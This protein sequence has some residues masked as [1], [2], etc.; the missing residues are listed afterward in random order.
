MS[1]ILIYSKEEAKRNS[2]SIEKYKE[3]LDIM[4]ML[5]E[6][7]NFSCSADFVIN[8]TNSFEIAEHFEKK[9]IRVFNPSSLTRLANNKQKCYEFMQNN[10]IEILPIHYRIPPLVMKPVDGKGGKNVTLITDGNIPQRE[11]YVYQ[12][13]ASELGK[14]LRVWLIGGRIIASVLRESKSDFRANFCL[15]GTASIYNL[16]AE[17]TALIRKIS[18]L[19][20]Y[21]YIGM[22]F[23]FD[24]GKMVF[25]E[26][27]DSVGARMIYSKTNIDIIKEYCE[28]IKNSI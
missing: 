3:N 2:F 16:S 26:I 11:G 6:N 4:L 9:G 8:R 22:D 27:E 14:D 7:I 24:K 12:K 21:D 19:F 1:G 13:A 17:E 5:Q 25:N 23:V 15:G 28:Y 20:N 10:S 18:S